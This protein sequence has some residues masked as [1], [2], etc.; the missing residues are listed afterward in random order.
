MVEYLQGPAITPGVWNFVA[1]SVL[2]QNWVTFYVGNASSSGVLSQI[3]L[4]IGV[5]DAA[6]TLPLLIG[7]NP[8]NPTG[9]SPLMSWKFSALHYIHGSSIPS[10]KQAPWANASPP[11]FAVILVQMS[12][13][14]TLYLGLMILA[15]F[16]SFTP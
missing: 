10:G 14:D 3:S 11:A 4:P 6:N 1:V 2:P 15:L 9:I 8:S 12:M 16:T 7:K 13:P 5:T